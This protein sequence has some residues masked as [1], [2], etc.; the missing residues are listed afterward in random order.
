M[1]ATEELERINRSSRESGEAEGKGQGD[2]S[3]RNADVGNVDL[4]RGSS[5]FSGVLTS[6]AGAGGDNDYGDD[7][8]ESGGNGGGKLLVDF[9]NSDDDDDDSSGDGW[10]DDNEPS[11]D[12]HASR[13]AG[14]NVRTYGSEPVNTSASSSSATFNPQPRINPISAVSCTPKTNPPSQGEIPGGARRNS[15]V[16]QPVALGGL[17]GLDDSDYG[18]SDD[19][20]AVSPGN[21]APEVPNHRPMVGGF[22]AAAYEAARAHHYAQ[23]QRMAKYNSQKSKGPRPSPPA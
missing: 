11:Q 10:A 21:S 6:V 2:P 7:D 8:G 22:A 20:D 16:M 14:S 23:K 5:I 13:S 18:S 19:D 12:R 1:S 4:R 15:V 3:V 9:P 17:A